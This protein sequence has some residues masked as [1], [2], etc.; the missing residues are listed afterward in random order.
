MLAYTAALDA[1]GQHQSELQCSVC[2]AQG[3]AFSLYLRLGRWV[4]LNCMA[5]GLDA[6]MPQCS[7]CA[8]E[9]FGALKLWSSEDCQ[10]FWCRCL[11]F[12]VC[13]VVSCIRHVRMHWC[14]DAGSCAFG[15]ELM[16]WRGV[17]WR[18][19]L[20]IEVKFDDPRESLE[21]LY[22][23]GVMSRIIICMQA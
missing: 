7:L 20:C 17:L 10:S 5:A 18:W 21:K 23:F 6:E 2:V 3:T 8:G 15:L 13:E 16:L 9:Y 12:F 4:W 11:A 1:S 22:Y 14:I 19:G